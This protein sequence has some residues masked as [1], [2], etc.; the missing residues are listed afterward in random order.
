M[1]VCKGCGTGSSKSFCILVFQF[2]PPNYDI[3]KECD[4]AN[5]SKIFIFNLILISI[6]NDGLLN[7]IYY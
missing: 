2:T 3:T 4:D 1:C 7:N 6:K 5:V